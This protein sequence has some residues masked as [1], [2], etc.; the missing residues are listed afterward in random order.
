M[1]EPQKMKFSDSITTKKM[2]LFS[3]QAIISGLLFGMWGQVQYFAAAVLLIPPAVIP[4]IYLV[5][6]IVDG[7]NDPL[8]GY[9]ADRSKRFTSKFGKRFLWIM[10]GA[11]IGPLLLILSFLQVS[12]DISISVIWLIIIMAV[13]ETFMTSYE[14]NHSALF[15]D[16]FR[17]SSHRRKVLVIGSIIGGLFTIVTGAMIPRLIV[18]IGYLGTVIT[19]VIIAYLFIIPYSFGIREPAEM[20]SFRTKLDEEKKGTS[21]VKVIIKRVFRDKNWM[22]IVV[23]GFLWSIAG[24]CWIYGLNYFVNHGLGLDIGY[25]AI[26]LLMQ[27]VIGFLFAPVWVWISKKVGV[28]KAY[29]AGMLLNLISDFSFIFVRNILGVIII[30]TFAGIGYS[31]TYG[32]IFGL[33]QAEGIDNAAVK[34]G[35]REEGSYTGILKIFTAFSYFFQ[36][37]IFAI[38]AGITGYNPALGAG[39]S[40]TAKFGLKFQMSIIPMIILL[41]GLLIFVLLYRI[42][43]EDAITNKIKLEEMNL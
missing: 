21:P 16:L 39:N 34:S 30:F 13:Y 4:L 36:T 6:S 42:S 41:I 35:K 19:V 32:V 27:N 31:A 12:A 33:L 2:F 38:V 22:G 25:T 23:A 24:A 11:G 28:K 7:I 43:K 14:I 40:D 15:P 1:T 9:L 3:L 10:V 8:I 37:I 17:E 20:R 26:P 5:Y 29:I 18:S